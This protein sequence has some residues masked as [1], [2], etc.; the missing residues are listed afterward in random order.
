MLN[1]KKAISDIR[2]PFRAAIYTSKVNLLLKKINPG[3]IH[4]HFIYPN[5]FTLRKPHIIHTHGSDV[6]NMRERAYLR[7]PFKKILD[8]AKAVIAVSNYNKE[9][10]E[11]IVDDDKIEVIYNHVN[12][13]KFRP[14]KKDL[15]NKKTILY[16]GRFSREKGMDVLVELNK[17]LPEEYQIVC[18]GFGPL[19]GYIIKNGI[20]VIP[21]SASPEDYI[22]SALC[23][24][25]PSSHE[26]LPFTVLE[27]MACGKYPLAT[28]VDAVTEVIRDKENGFLIERDAGDI[29]RTILDNEDRFSKTNEGG[30]QTVHEKFSIKESI[31]KHKRLYES[32]E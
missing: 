17:I 28:A 18:L 3:I 8:R 14:E 20:K 4:S 27:A 12:T 7:Y 11:G 22:N 31:E 2:A 6:H 15:F 9:I 23:L 5:A 26:G 32:L 19:K 10:L 13:E 25:L 29:L 24:I 30:I 1:T 21:Y 16:V